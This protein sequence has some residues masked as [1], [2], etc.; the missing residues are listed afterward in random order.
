MTYQLRQTTRRS[1]LGI[2]A[3]PAV[4]SAASLMP[5]YV[6][7]THILWADGVHDDTE[8]LR[9]WLRRGRVVYLNGSHVQEVLQNARI[10][11]VNPRLAGI[12]ECFI[13]W[14]PDEIG[15]T[16]TYAGLPEHMRP[17]LRTDRYYSD[18]KW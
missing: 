2:L 12:R 14:Q 11:A 16:L 5:L 9:V 8:A 7:R 18:R 3:A 15:S 17:E 1:F 10:S 4:V 13:A 6:P